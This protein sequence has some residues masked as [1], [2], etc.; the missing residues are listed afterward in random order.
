MATLDNRYKIN[1]LV[2]TSQT[3]LENMTAITNSCNTWLSYDALVGKWS[4]IINREGSAEYQFNDSNIVGPINLSTT[5][6]TGYYNSVE[7]RF[8]N[9]E[10]RDREDYVLLEIP[11]DQR[12]PNEP[13]NRLVIN[14]PLVNNQIQAQLI[15]LIE[16]KQSR[17]DQVIEFVTDFSYINIPAGTIIS[18]TNSVYGWT[19]QLFRVLTMTEQQT[20][21]TIQISITA[22]IYDAD[23][24]SDDDLYLYLRETEDG[25]IELDPL[26]D[27]S[28]VTNSTA[29]VDSDTGQISPLLFALPLLLSLLDGLNAGESNQMVT[30]ILD[31]IQAQTGNDITNALIAAQIGSVNVANIRQSTTI[32]DFVEL[33][34]TVFV[35]P[36][37]GSYTITV[38]FDSNGSAAAGGRGEFW[39]EEEDYCLGRVRLFDQLVGGNQIYI[40]GSGGPGA[41]YWTDF[42]TNG[43]VQLEA[44]RSYRL[45][46]S[47]VN[48][49]ESN[50]SGTANV[51]TGWQVL[52]FKE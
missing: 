23:I 40:E 17:L 12:L 29:V 49:T 6:L 7:V 9:L 34:S 50:T 8:H 46:F 31:G 1:G 27:V 37:T 26:V 42:V 28:P 38:F 5:P 13:D 22:Q 19:N 4:V 2:D 33:G 3:A 43:L 24:Y 44:G 39:G 20:E 15:G 48:Y 36:S 35:A 10:L 14:A 32:T 30:G 52:T 51:T 11:A 41:F 21:D 47:W 16:L 25:L 18:V 45:E